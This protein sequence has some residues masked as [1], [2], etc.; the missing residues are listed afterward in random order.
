MAK[1]L[2]NQDLLFGIKLILY[3]QVASTFSFKY[4][5]N[6]L[7]SVDSHVRQASDFQSSF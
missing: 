2:Q 1:M 3:H 4:N 5:C 7:L 6:Y